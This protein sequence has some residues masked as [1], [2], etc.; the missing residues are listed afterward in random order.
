MKRILLVLFLKTI[1]LTAAFADGEQV[2]VD[3]SSG[4]TT[5]PDQLGRI[6]PCTSRQ[7]EILYSIPTGYTAVKEFDWYANGVLV[8]TTIGNNPFADI[9]ATANSFTIVCKATY[10]NS[11]GAVSG[12]YTSTSFSPEVNLAALNTI[13]QTGQAIEGSSNPVTFSTSEVTGNS[14]VYSPPTTDF[15]IEW[16]L[17]A[18]WTF[19][20]ANTGTSV[21]AIPDATTSGNVV[22]K[23]QFNACAYNTSV[24]LAV[25]RATPPPSFSSSNATDPCG[26]SQSYSINPAPG[27]TSYT[28]SI[29]GNASCTFTANGLQTLTT[30]ATSVNVGFPATGG[31]FTLGAVAN[32]GNNTSS[33]DT[34]AFYWYGLPTMSLSI[35]KWTGYTFFASAT[36]F[37]GLSYT[38]TLNGHT[39]PGGGAGNS[40]TLSDAINCG[41]TGQS[42]SVYGTGACGTTNTATLPLYIKCSSGGPQVVVAHASPNPTQGML[43]VWLSDTDSTGQ[44][45]T[46]ISHPI[47][48][49]RIVDKTG[50]IIRKFEYGEGS[51][52]IDINTGGI[53][54]DIYILQ[55][56]DGLQW[57]LREILIK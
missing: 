29:T 1:F 5:D 27:A 49:V 30:A 2:A 7:Y 40:S 20:G 6:N 35:T 13:T 47:R 31:G 34:T 55:V 22:A 9:V 26:A 33:S 37:A 46:K 12:V 28:Y 38:W 57:S 18:N 14:F 16:Q 17:P 53:N 23:M 56:F 54:P 51:Q 42:I 8:K 44:K 50:K 24:T 39:Y 15:T 10:T 19:S 3:L 48:A 21:I 36:Y 11:T 32:Y 41:V 25:V 43:K 52:E 4:P 45:V